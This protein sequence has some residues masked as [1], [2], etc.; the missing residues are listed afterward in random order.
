MAGS[1]AGL[2]ADALGYSEEAL[3]RIYES[4]L[5]EIRSNPNVEY[6]LEP[7]FNQ[8]ENARQEIIRLGGN[9][10]ALVSDDTN[11]WLNDVLVGRNEVTEEV[12]PINP[13]TGEAST[14]EALDVE[15]RQLEDDIIAA[16]AELERVRGTD[17]ELFAAGLPNKLREDKV[18]INRAMTDAG[19]VAPDDLT[20]RELLELGGYDPD[21]AT[22]RIG[23]VRTETRRSNNRISRLAR[24]LE[25]NQGTL[26]EDFST[27]EL[28]EQYLIVLPRIANTEE[29]DKVLAIR[30]LR[31]QIEANQRFMVERIVDIEDAD[32]IAQQTAINNGQARAEVTREASITEAT[33]VALR[34]GSLP[35][36]IASPAVPS[37]L[38]E[39]TATNADT[40]DVQTLRR[41]MNPDGR[42]TT[43]HD[44]YLDDVMEEVNRRYGQDFPDYDNLTAFSAGMKTIFPF[45]TYEAHRFAWYLPREALRHPGTYNAF[46]RYRDN[47]NQGYTHIP[48]TKLDINPLRGTI[49]MGG[50]RRLSNRDYPEFYDQFGPAAGAF[51]MVSRAGFFPGAPIGLVFATFGA[52]T[53]VTQFGE[54]APAWTKTMA[55]GLAATVPGTKL[56]NFMKHI[57]PDRFRDFQQS[58]EVSKN[59]YEGVELLSKRLR[60]EQLTDEEESQWD[61]GSRGLGWF[62]ILS[63]QSSLIRLNPGQR[64]EVQEAADVL[65]NELTGV[66]IDSLRDLRRNNL[67]FEDVFGPLPP[68]VQKAVFEVEGFSKWSG[69]SIA[70]IPSQLQQRVLIQ[71][72]FWATVQANRIVERDYMVRIESDVR[73]GTRSMLD[74]RRERSASIERR[75]NFITTKQREDRYR[76]VPMK[77]DDRITFAQENNMLEPILH[78][79]EE[80]RELYFAQ[81]LEER[82]NYETGQ[83][84]DDWDSFFAYR[85]AVE[86]SLPDEFLADLIRLNQTE[87]TAL[88]L[89]HFQVNKELF[90]PYHALFDIVLAEFDPTDQTLIKEHRDTDTLRAQQ[91]QEITVEIDG[92]RRQLISLFTTRLQQAH[93]NLRTANPE[94]DAWLNVFR[95]V[96]GFKTDIAEQRFNNIRRELGIK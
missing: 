50:M 38:V 17:D 12:L 64:I 11:Q 93:S 33:R 74:W 89:T 96:R 83:F 48:G 23:R 35:T 46:G 95:E 8:L 31:D 47:T 71:R 87:S 75:V 77:L 51:D 69:A 45:W 40:L 79:M 28:E 86:Q 94:L 4:L 42:P 62:S 59:G 80:L 63:E 84:E 15:V 44:E 24:E 9:R 7:A 19:I 3:G 92:E 14:F 10:G 21:F 66:P 65:L 52:S 2:D 29:I 25:T 36:R 58:R 26:L 32:I 1:A 27:A 41:L 30:M 67:R 82:F 43:G 22:T 90:R 20:A 78:P 61:S 57:L 6:G 39:F 85:E 53:G 5:K 55:G 18:Q 49:L 68:D 54:I 76:D 56:D 73:N 91:I 60:N 72:E 16:E 13:R 70:L 81:P 34:E 37:R 88:E